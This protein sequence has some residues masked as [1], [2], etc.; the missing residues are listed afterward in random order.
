MSPKTPGYT[1]ILYLADIIHRFVSLE[2]RE[3]S[4]RPTPKSKGGS[5]DLGVA[6]NIL[7]Y[8]RQNV[9]G[10]SVCNARRVKV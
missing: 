4:S 5:G 7:C 3:Y 1:I 9:R 2:A 10:P 6:A 8:Q